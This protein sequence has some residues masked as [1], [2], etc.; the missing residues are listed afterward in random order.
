MSYFL[1][2][3]GL[4]F[5]VLPLLVALGIAPDDDAPSQ[6]VSFEG[7]K[8]YGIVLICCW[9]V[10]AVMLILSFRSVFL[11]HDEQS[12][13]VG[14]KWLN[15][16]FSTSTYKRSDVSLRNSINDNGEA[17]LFIERRIN[18]RSHSK[19]I[20]SGGDP[21]VYQRVV[22]LYAEYSVNPP[23]RTGSE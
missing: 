13:F 4:I 14:E 17:S 5:L 3:I 10:A 12:L 22:D 9:M 7:L 23:D 20:C 11:W 6:P 15:F 1:A 19:N 2:P 16:H 21:A 8:Y 18:G